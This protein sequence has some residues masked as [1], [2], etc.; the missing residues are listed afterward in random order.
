MWEWLITPTI[1]Q[2]TLRQLGI[3][4]LGSTL[5]SQLGVRVIANEELV[6]ELQTFCEEHY[7]VRPTFA[8]VFNHP[9]T[10]IYVW[11]PPDRPQ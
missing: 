3:V 6:H 1:M 10:I 8:L 2:S 7:R 4:D 5:C 9:R 11:A